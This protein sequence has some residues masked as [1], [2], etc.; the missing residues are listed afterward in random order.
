M[1]FKVEIVGLLLVLGIIGLVVFAARYYR[2]EGFQDLLSVETPFVDK[3]S[4]VY[5]NYNKDVMTNSNVNNMASALATPDVFL[6]MN[7][8][9][10]EL[11]AQRLV[12]DP[13]NGY[14]DY[15]D[16]YCRGAL[17]PANL[18]RHERGA[19][20]G[21]G[22][23]YVS[24]PTLTSTGVLGTMD[25]PVFT[26]NL[27]GGGQW[28]WDLA[29]AQELEDI[30][31]CKQ[32]TAC[33]VIDT[34]NIHLR[35]GFCA[36][37]GHAVPINTDGS[38]KYTKNP[39]GTC[40]TTLI[41]NSDKC[42]SENIYEPVIAW[43]GTDCKTYG[44]PSPDNS[45]R[46]YNKT[47]CD[48][49]NGRW[50]PNGECLMLQGGSY[51]AACKGLNAPIKKGNACTHN[52]DGRLTAAC[53]LLLTRSLGYTDLGAMRRIIKNNGRVDETD[54]VAIAQLA[55]VGVSVPVEILNGGGT[56]DK[57]TAANL[58]MRI[59][60]Q[61][62]IGIHTRVREAA[63]WFVVGSPDFNPCNFDKDEM[64]PFPKTCLQQLWRMSGCQ[65]AGTK[66]PNTNITED[67]EFLSWG[68]I[69]N[70]F[71]YMYDSMAMRND[72]AV[73]DEHVKQCLG[74]D[75]ARKSPKC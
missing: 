40:G 37:S 62:R 47:D 61:I 70:K 42:P 59:K 46:L 32:I 6:P 4:V 29:K 53:L 5:Q 13:T 41:L 3:Q 57:N 25:G 11:I 71:K 36:S 31:V 1:V 10:G 65:A 28:I 23:W 38:E 18:P 20:D 17:Q 30:K 33:E 50:I 34:D 15:D 75:V 16:K 69:A 48:A 58:Y 7:I 67:Y 66:Y 74:I 26:D 27:P 55:N 19:R 8:V 45:I 24:D 54:K 49:M 9:N 56:I 64:G 73:Q 44:Y 68:G 2:T 22:W 52:S 39:A 12:P 51:S 60:E 43:D 63:K 14:T 21:C 35:C 72:P